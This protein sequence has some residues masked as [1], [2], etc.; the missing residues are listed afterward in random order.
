M[1]LFIWFYFYR[2][3]YNFF[4]YTPVRYMAWVRVRFACT[5]GFSRS[6]V[7]LFVN[8]GSLVLRTF[9]SRPRWIYIEPLLC[10]PFFY[11]PLPYPALP[12]FASRKIS[13][14]SSPDIVRQ[15]KDFRDIVVVL[16]RMQVPQERAL[17]EGMR[18][19]RREKAWVIE[20]KIKS[21]FPSN[22]PGGWTS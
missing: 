3:V 1:E 19:I 2:I 20:D 11:Y 18:E 5:G 6:G 10:F 21:D 4:Y 12:P 8:T 22:I 9:T 15:R 13:H 16:N 17:L 14:L 7:S